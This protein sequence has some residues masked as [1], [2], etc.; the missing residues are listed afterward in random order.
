MARMAKIKIEF[1]LEGERKVDELISQ[2]TDR[3]K[4]LAE[5]P[6]Y[7]NIIVQRKEP[8]KRKWFQFWKR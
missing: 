7:F 4:E 5:T 3:I 2:I 8:E 1:Q 6:I